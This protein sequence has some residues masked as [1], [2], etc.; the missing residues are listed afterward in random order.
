MRAR[1]VGPLTNAESDA[2]HADRAALL[3]ALDALMRACEAL[4]TRTD[5]RKLFFA[6]IV[7]LPLLLAAM[8]LD[9]Q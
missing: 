2:A 5:A 8:M 6:S 1:G 9:K 3:A 4:R 7:Y